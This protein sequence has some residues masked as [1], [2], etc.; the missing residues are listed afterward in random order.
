[1][2]EQAKQLGLA[3]SDQSSRARSWK[4]RISEGADGQF[5]RALL[6]PGPAQRVLSEAGL[7]AEQ[8]AAM[9]R[10]HLAEAIAGDLTVPVAAQEAIHRYTSERRA[11]AYFVLPPEAGRRDPG[12]HARTAPDLLQRAQERRSRRRNTGP[13]PSW[14]SMRP[15]SPSPTP[16]SDADARQRLRAGEGEVRHTRAPHDPAD[17]LPDTGRGRGCRRQAEGRH[18]LRRDRRPSATSLRRTSSSAPSP[19]REMLDQAVADG[20]LRPRE[21]RASARPSPGRFGPV[22]VRVTDDP[23]GGRTPVRGGRGGDPQRSRRAARRRPRS[24]RST[25]QIEDQRAGARPLAEIAKDKG[26]TLV[27]VPAIDHG[28]RDKAGN[29]VELP[30]REALRREPSSPPISA[31]TTSRSASRVAAMSGTT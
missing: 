4:T 17:L 25:T 2:T 27:Q 26:L 11:A 12:R 24:T 14:P 30:E 7:R 29:V 20:G 10:L 15:R 18:D 31:S 28:G 23:A 9:A 1:M 8:R 16:C 3:V 5:N 22:L 6:R 19:R 13:S 21:G